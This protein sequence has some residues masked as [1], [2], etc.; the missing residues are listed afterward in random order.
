MSVFRCKQF[1]IAHDKS[2]FKV[3]TDAVLL[4]AWVSVPK[5]CKYILDI[6]S[7]CGIV[8]LMLAQRSDAMITGVDIDKDSIEEAIENA[9]K[10]PWKNRITFKHTSVQ[11]FC[12]PEYKHAFDLIVSNPPFFAD[13]LKSPLHTRNISR[14]TDTLLFEDLILSVNYCL[15]ISGIFAII[16][17]V[18]VTKIIQE[19]CKNQGLFCTAILQIQ[20]KDNKAANRNILLFAHEEKQIQIQNLIIRNSSNEYTNTYRSLTKE[21]YLDF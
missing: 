3:G 5:K 10:S 8:S 18:T 9:D 15:S 12:T 7:G 19:Q 4:G 14:H 11:K 13:A 16:I 6:G 17:P 20:P 1:E 2:A 21:F